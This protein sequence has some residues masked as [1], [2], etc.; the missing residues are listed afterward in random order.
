MMLP[1]QDIPY[2]RAWPARTDFEHVRSL[3]PQL[4]GAS[5]DQQ[6]PYSQFYAASR[7]TLAVNR[8]APALRGVL[9]GFEIV[10]PRDHKNRPTAY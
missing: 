9:E 8:G 1:N 3:K 4:S 2:C 10:T 5:R 7:V 6:R